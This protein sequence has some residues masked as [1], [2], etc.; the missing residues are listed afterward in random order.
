MKIMFKKNEN[1]FTLIEML[2]VVVII[3]IFASI[4]RPT[5]QSSLKS[6]RMRGAGR[7]ITSA[8]RTARRTAIMLKTK[9]HLVI[10]LDNNSIQI[11]YEDEDSNR[12]LLPNSRYEMAEGVNLTG[13]LQTSTTTSG[14]V[15]VTFLEKGTTSSS[16]NLIYFSYQPM[17]SADHSSTNKYEFK[18]VRI[19]N[20]SGRP[21]LIELGVGGDFSG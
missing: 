5:V 16:Q 17:T 15:N 6:I 21:Q 19:D 8:S 3:G 7:L 20:S 18:T 11:E 2:V 4:S 14:I 1:G 10:D 9:V 13:V 12:V